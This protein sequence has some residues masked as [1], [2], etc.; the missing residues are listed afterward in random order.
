MTSLYQSAGGQVF[1]K[2]DNHTLRRDEV[3]DMVD[4][5]GALLV[6]W[7]ETELC[8]VKLND[9]IVKSDLPPKTI[10]RVFLPVRRVGVT[11]G[12]MEA[13]PKPQ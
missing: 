10:V 3:S 7:A 4:L 12:S 8:T 11:A 9:T 13:D 1:V 6:G 5:N 2:L